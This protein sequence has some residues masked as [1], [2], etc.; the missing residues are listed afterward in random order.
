[1][2]VPPR[3]GEPVCDFTACLRQHAKDRNLDRTARYY[4]VCAYA[5]NQWNV[6]GE[7]GARFLS[8]VPEGRSVG[9]L[10]AMGQE[11]SCSIL[12]LICGFI[13]FESIHL[14]IYMGMGQYL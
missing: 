3:W 5:N 12:Q 13:G 11:R 8:V 10:E 4:W 14:H 6:S 7:I 1:M 2:G 9:Q